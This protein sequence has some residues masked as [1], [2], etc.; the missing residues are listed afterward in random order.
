[1][2]EGVVVGEAGVLVLGGTGEARRLADRLAGA[3]VTVTTSLAGLTRHAAPTSGTIRTGGFGGPDGLAAWL[4]EH[5][6]SCVVDAT[7][8]FAAQ[9]SSNAALACGRLG[10]P[11]LR[12]ARPGWSEHP[13]ASSWTWVATHPDAAGTARRLCDSCAGSVLL[14][15]GRQST[16]AYVGSLGDRR[17]VARVVESGGLVLPDEW[18][19]LEDRGPFAHE[20]EWELFADHEVRVLVTKDSG[21]TATAPKLDVAREF[22]AR[23]VVVRRPALAPG[24]ASVADVRAA[25]HWCLATLSRRRPGPVPRP[26]RSP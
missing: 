7:H 12:V 22:D 17:V 6:T 13:D 18:L 1:M 15:V 21:G 10:V 19:V 23:V 14:T 16:S 11:L 9:M 4:R 26:D 20:R 2:A 5:G 24:V 8:P 25:A 3:G